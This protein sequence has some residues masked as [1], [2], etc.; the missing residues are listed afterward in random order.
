MR[1]SGCHFYVSRLR[2]YL[3]EALTATETERVRDHLAGCPAC[4]AKLEAM[5]E[6]T[7]LVR[8]VPAEVEP[9]PHFGPDLQV[10]L[11]R[12]RSKQAHPL[13]PASRPRWSRRYSLAGLTLAGAVVALI[14]GAPPRIGAQDLV[15]KVQESWRQL[16]S[17]SCVFVTE[18]VVAGHP[19]RFVQRQWFAKPDLFRLETNKDYPERVYIQ[20][21]RVTTVIPGGR[22]RGKPLSIIRPRHA[23]EEG[24]PFPFGAEWPS[25]YDITMDALVR[26]LRA[27]QGCEL[28]GTEMVAG[29]LC[30]GLKY[31]S[32]RPV[33]RLPTHYLVWVDQESF[34]PLK[35]KI[36]RDAENNRVSTAVDL[37]TNV[38]APSDTFRYE[39]S[40]NTFQV[41]GEVEPFVFTLGMSTPRPEQFERD[42][43]GATRGEMERR[44]AAVPFPVFAPAAL[45][46][47]YSL[48]R[49]RASAGR[50]LDAY[51]ID[52]STGM[53]IKL[54]EQP[55]ASAGQ[56]P[57]GGT[58]IP[59]DDPSKP[60][61][62]WH[63]L[64]RPAPIQYL[65]WDQGAT[66]LSLAAAGLNR[67]Q[68]L[69]I[70]GSM[71]L[72]GKPAP[73]PAAILAE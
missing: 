48:V 63:E 50:W 53:V 19:R 15:G 27:Q 52:N 71:A 12:L 21:D 28:L 16:Q 7:R 68:A 72:V 61:C 40:S 25:S 32:Q 60:A 54:L 73:A 23:R 45:P 33:D 62:R 20:R 51:W 24:L 37:Q 31:H 8:S 46:A 58:I 41:V 9:P 65:S 44:A 59:L 30:Y 6:V 10:R 18:G 5:S 26:E 4:Q 17:Y 14:F 3:D 22:W 34:L 56:D 1:N 11:A 66:R 49:V 67:A 42:P 47:G 43:V 35:I 39:P 70:A 13:Y 38:M 29:R 36:Y 69:R 64:R 2:A 55:L 57:E